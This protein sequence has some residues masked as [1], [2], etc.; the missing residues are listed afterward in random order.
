MSP[1]AGV[2][3]EP[4]PAHLIEGLGPPKGKTA[5]VSSFLHDKSCKTYGLN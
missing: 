1:Y 5:P 4:F 3:G 2:R